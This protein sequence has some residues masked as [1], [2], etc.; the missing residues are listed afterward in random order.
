MQVP[1]YLNKIN[2]DK[3][4]IECGIIFE[5]THPS[6]SELSWLIKFL[7][8]VGYSKTELQDLICK[9]AQWSDYSEAKSSRILRTI[10]KS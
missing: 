1:E 2:S 6:P 5:K 9:H 7:K 3:K 10:F 8:F 4:A